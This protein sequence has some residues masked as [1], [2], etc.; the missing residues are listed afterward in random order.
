MFFTWRLSRKFSKYPSSLLFRITTCYLILVIV[1]LIIQ[2][3]KNDNFEKIG[4]IT[5]LVIN[6]QTSILNIIYFFSCLRIIKNSQDGLLLA[7]RFD[8]SIF[9]LNLFMSVLFLGLLFSNFE[10]KFCFVGSCFINPSNKLYMQ[11]FPNI[12]ESSILILCFIYH[13]YNFLNKQLNNDL[14]KIVAY[15]LIYFC[16]NTLDTFIRYMKMKNRNYRYDD[17]CSIHDYC[18]IIKSFIF[19]I[20]FGLSSQNLSEWIKAFTDDKD[21]NMVKDEINEISQIKNRLKLNRTII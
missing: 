11:I 7:I 1:L 20:F 3:S 9:Y 12:I 18:I 13:L 2:I 8:K 16:Y 5:I 14:K 21:D 4:L 17:Y 10:I 6:Y 19:F 15:E